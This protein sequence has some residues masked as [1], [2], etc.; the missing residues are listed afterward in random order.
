[1]QYKVWVEDNLDVE[2]ELFP[3]LSDEEKVELAQFR[4]WQKTADPDQVSY[5]IS[6]LPARLMSAYIAEFVGPVPVRW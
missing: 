1:M 4:V 5:F 3:N 6:R 2:E